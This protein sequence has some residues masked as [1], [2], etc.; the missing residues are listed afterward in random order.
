MEAIANTLGEW[1]AA[2]EYGDIPTDVQSEAKRC[3]IDVVG[4]ALAG[5]RHDVGRKS[6]EHIKREYAEGACTLFGD[7]S[8]VS[9]SAAAFANAV[10]AHAYDF[11]DTCYAGITHGSAVVFPAVLAAAEAECVTGERLLTAFIA[12]VE[13]EYALGASVGD[14]LFFKGWHPTTVLGSIGATAGVAKILGL[15]ADKTAQALGVAASQAGSLQTGKGTPVKPFLA[16]RAAESGVHFAR[17]AGMGLPAPLDAFEKERGFFDI[18]N[19][20][21][22]DLS[23]L[24]NLGSV[25]RLVDPGIAF[26]LYP[27]CSAAQAAVEETARILARENIDGDA[28]NEVLCEVTHLV[29]VSLDHDRPRTPVEAQFSMPF[30]V[31]CMLV[32]GD[33]GLAQLDEETLADPRLRAVMPRIGMRISRQLAEDPETPRKCPEGA[34]ITVRTVDG[35]EIRR[36]NGAATGLPANPMPDID[37]DRKFRDCA[38]FA[39][40]DTERAGVLLGRLRTVE[41]LAAATDLLAS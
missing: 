1:I 32:F 16:G 35:R 28:V 37:L 38:L 36:F 40:E 17:M 9:S 13:T 23:A 29:H 8:R 2:L 12:G 15:D 33:L 22:R 4:V 25:Y 39:G 20:G 7:R 11:D 30:A 10:A 24:A 6:R 31:G 34:F 14:H 5:T 26:K 18:V 41:G 19:D 27:V 3:L 21:K